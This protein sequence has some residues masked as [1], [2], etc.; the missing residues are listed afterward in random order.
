MT[1]TMPATIQVGLPQVGQPLD[2]AVL[3]SR[4]TGRHENGVDDGQVDV[5][6]LGFQRAV[7]V[8]HVHDGQVGA[9]EP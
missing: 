3:G 6:A 9:F 1:A 5:G 4:L 2:V 8:P 7:F